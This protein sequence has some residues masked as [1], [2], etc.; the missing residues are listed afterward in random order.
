MITS[1][2]RPTALCIARA[3]KKGGGLAN[4][5]WIFLACGHR[6]QAPA[7]IPASGFLGTGLEPTRFAHCG[8]CSEIE[9]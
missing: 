5:V 9:P 8:G 2:P 6:L 7:D 3:V 4:C 1:R